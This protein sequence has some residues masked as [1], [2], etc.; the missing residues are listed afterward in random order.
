MAFTL[1][2]LVPTLAFLLF[3][4]WFDTARNLRSEDAPLA[5][6]ALLLFLAA[7]CT[8]VVYWIGRAFRRGR[9]DFDGH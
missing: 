2:A 6:F 9:T 7:I 5:L 8:V 3:V 4:I 1:K